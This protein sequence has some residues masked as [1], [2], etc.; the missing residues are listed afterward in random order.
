MAKRKHTAL[1][2]IGRLTILENSS[3]LIKPLC[4]L[5]IINIKTL[6]IH[7]VI[8]KCFKNNGIRVYYGQI[9]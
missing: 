8:L 4:S 7:I 3:E 1:C 6:K 9:N 2:C 5:N